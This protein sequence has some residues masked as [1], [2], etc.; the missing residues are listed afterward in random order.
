MGPGLRLPFDFDPEALRRDL[1]ELSADDWQ[2]HYNQRDFGGLWQGVALRSATGSPSDLNAVAD[3]FQDTALLDRCAFFKRVLDAFQCPLRSVRLLSLAPGSFI[4]EHSDHALDYE[5]GEVRIHVPIQTSPGVEFYVCG[6]RLHLEEGGC[7]YVNVNLP[8]RVKNRGAADRVHLVIDAQVN[9][10]VRDL[11]EIHGREIPRMAL[12]PSGLEEFRKLVLADE[13]LQQPLREIREREELV[14]AAVALGAKLGVDLDPSDVESGFRSDATRTDEIPGGWTP[15]RVAFPNA[16]LL[17]TGERR[18]TEPFFE[19]TVRVCRRNPFAALFR[20]T[21]RFPNAPAQPGIAPSGFIFHM[22]RCGSTLVSQMF[23]AIRRTVVISEAPP[24]DE[25]LRGNADRLP[26][27]IG[28]LGQPRTGEET[29]LVVKLDAWHL[30]AL[31]A[32]R[33]A[34]PDVPLLLVRRNPEEILQSWM[35]QPGKQSIP[36]ALDPS[37]LG[38]DVDRAA[39]MNRQEWCDAVLAGLIRMADGFENDNLGMTVHYRELPEAVISRVA[40]HF[41]LELSDDEVE[42]MRRT[43]YFDAKNP[44]QP[45]DTIVRFPNGI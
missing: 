20:R 26:W 32:I 39:G 44:G 5:D 12:P 29:H 41:G 9:Q 34:F 13:E 10:W 35:R 22:S 18:F 36:G 33:A 30:H 7:Y 1:A 16:E 19:D 45:F 28:L 38:I 21:V 40:G 24:I 4:R 11:F 27:V 14:S 31:P 43:A 15:V 23:A 42:I 2:P 17:W 25:I 6:E 8:H 3:T 37:V